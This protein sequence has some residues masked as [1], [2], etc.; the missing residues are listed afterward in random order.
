M[1]FWSLSSK[2][3]RHASVLL[4]TAAS[5]VS[6]IGFAQATTSQST[7]STSASLQAAG[8]I[9]NQTT[10]GPASQDYTHVE[11]VGIAAYVQEQLNTPPYL[12]PLVVPQ[13]EY[14]LPD[15]S[16]WNCGPEAWWWHDVLFGQDQLRQRVA[17]ALSKLFVVSYSEVDAR[18]FPY[19]LNA[20]SRDAFGNWSTLMQDVSLSPAMGT[21]L[22]TANSQA[23]TAGG[24]ANENFARE[25]MQLFSI[26]TVA[27]NQDGSV[28][29]DSNG[30]PIPTY[31]STTV[32]NFARAFTG[33]TFATATCTQPTKPEHYWW[34]QPPGTGCAMLPLE[35]YHDTLQK[36][37]LRGEVLPAGQSAEADFKAAL[38]NV[39]NDPSLPPFV[40]RRLIQSLV[41]SNPS[42]AYISR[43]AGVFI[44]DGSG[45]RGDMKAVIRAILLDPEA[46]ADDTA[47][48]P[49]ADDGIMRDPIL[50][51]ASIMRSLGATQNLSEGGV[52]AAQFD[53]SLTDLGED[54]HNA[55]SV[56]SYYAPTFTIDGG[57][58]CAPEF[59]I[60]NSAALS[61]M[62]L[63][64]QDAI[65]N[66]FGGTANEFTLD[67]SATS[68]LGVIAAKQGPSALVSTLNALLLHGTMSS[69]MSSSIVGAIKGWDTAT[70]VRNS[71][72][73]IVTSPQY[74]VMI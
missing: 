20:L 64:A 15:C 29:L 19:Y 30:N 26:G 69:Q 47:T 11:Q 49:D 60:E 24:H 51:Y 38:L 54:P 10:F 6:G 18:Y 59:Q 40:C 42:P 8:R 45:V 5:C 17:F 65:D 32:Q 55:P 70:M 34:P 74:R 16:G 72:F 22:N 3:F 52:Y 73:L 50:W 1:S 2:Y 61:W 39:F 63:H 25:L 31:N 58:L 36:T 48:T 21:Y 23:A 4:L 9:L 35:Q 28:K 27:L 14:N 62:I 13:A 41:K 66:K 44:N 43:V 67:L 56:F 53:V 33:Y 57:S 46:R 7:S 71:V 68:P 37:L 12:M